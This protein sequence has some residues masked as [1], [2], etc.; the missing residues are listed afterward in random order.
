MKTERFASIVQ[1]AGNPVAHLLLISPEKDK[2]LQT[3]IRTNRVLTVHQNL[4]G[5]KADYGTIGFERGG[6]C[7]YFIF[8]RSLAKFREVRI[9]GINYDL[10]K[11]GASKEGGKT[12]AQ[13]QRS[14]SQTSEGDPAQRERP[15]KKVEPQECLPR[16]SFISQDL[17][18]RKSMTPRAK[19]FRRLRIKCDK[20]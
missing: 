13:P 2:I 18:S 10:L 3:A 15:K 4:T 6:A 5:N 14:A 20:Q 9:V 12:V 16:S 11:A 19:P 8:P 17:S 1:S 7:Q